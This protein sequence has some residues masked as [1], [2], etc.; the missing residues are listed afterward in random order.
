MLVQKPVDRAE[1]VLDALFEQK[2]ICFVYDRMD[3]ILL[4]RPRASQP[5]IPLPTSCRAV[6]NDPKGYDADR[7]MSGHNRSYVSSERSGDE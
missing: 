4:R 1:G 3:R 2:L 6:Q 7:S 5:A